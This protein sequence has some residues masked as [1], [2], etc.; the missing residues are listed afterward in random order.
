MERPITAALSSSERPRMPKTSLRPTPRSGHSI[1]DDHLVSSA[2]TPA[3]LVA[4]IAARS[5]TT[6]AEYVERLVHLA[7]AIVQAAADVQYRLL[8]WRHFVNAVRSRLTQTPPEDAPKAAHATEARGVT[9]S[10]YESFYDRDQLASAIRV[11]GDWDAPEIA[12]LVRRAASSPTIDGQFLR[13]L[14][15]DDMKL[16]FNAPN[17][18]SAMTRTRP[19]AP[20]MVPPPPSSATASPSATINPFGVQAAS[21]AAKP[22]EPAQVDLVEGVYD[23]FRKILVTPSQSVS[24][25]N[26]NPFLPAT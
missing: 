11:N 25:P 8:P 14:L 20:P 10:Y 9:P 12:D 5:V 21:S 26:S 19:P 1:S 24:E 7:F 2:K 3:M 23:P 6:I 4:G 15:D 17:V 22:L 13:C 18:A 16:P